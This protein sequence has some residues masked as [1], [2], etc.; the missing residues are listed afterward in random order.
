MNSDLAYAVQGRVLLYVHKQKHL[1]EI[2]QMYPADHYAMIDD[3]PQ[4]L[5]DSQAVLGDRLTTVFVKQ[6]KYANGSLPEHFAPAITVE[7]I[8]DLRLFKTEQ[9][10]M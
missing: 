5:H 7:H 8:G 1:D 2:L 3:K 10:Y 4:I 6:G 9:F